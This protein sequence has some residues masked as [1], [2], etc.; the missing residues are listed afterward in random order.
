MPQIDP[1]E[2][3]ALSL[4]GAEIIRGFPLHDV[5]LVEL[6]GDAPCSVPRLL[7]LLNGKQRPAVNPAVRALFWTR[8]VLG[9][10][11]RLDGPRARAR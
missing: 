9:R 10:L 2:F 6:E 11:L 5:W 8:S 7:A 3:E 1:G 4:R